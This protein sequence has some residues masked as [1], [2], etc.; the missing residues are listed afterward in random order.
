MLFRNTSFDIFDRW[1]TEINIFSLPVLKNLKYKND[2]L[3]DVISACECSYYRT[4]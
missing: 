4:R 3:L 2:I 1:G